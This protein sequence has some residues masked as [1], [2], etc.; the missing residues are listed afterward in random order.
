MNYMHIVHQSGHL[1]KKPYEWKH[2]EQP[3]PK[4]L[5]SIDIKELIKVGNAL[6]V[7][8]KVSVHQMTHTGDRLYEGKNYGKT[9]SLKY[10]LGGHQGIHIERSHMGLDSVEKSSLKCLLSRCLKDIIDMKSP[11][12]VRSEGKPSDLHLFSGCITELIQV[13]CPMNSSTLEKPSDRYLF[14]GV[15]K[16]FCVIK[17]LFIHCGKCVSVKCLFP[18]QQRTHTGER[19]HHTYIVE[20]PYSKTYQLIVHHYK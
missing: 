17:E 3:S 15:W 2:Y 13:R 18:V 11:L 7:K 20:M 6:N 12:H 19:H 9:L 10:A 4:S 14:R 8:S 5:T 16:T 1:E